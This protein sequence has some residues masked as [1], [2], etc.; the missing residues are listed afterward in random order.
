MSGGGH[1][2][3]R[4][5]SRRNPYLQHGETRIHSAVVGHL[6]DSTGHELDDGYRVAARMEDKRWKTAGCCSC[7]VLE[8][9]GSSQALFERGKALMVGFFYGYHLNR[10]SQLLSCPCPSCF[11]S[12]VVDVPF[13]LFSYREVHTMSLEKE[14]IPPQQLKTKSKPTPRPLSLR[15]LAALVLVTFTFWTTFSNHQSAHQRTLQRIQQC[16]ID[17]L[18]SDLSFLDAVAPIPASEFITRRDNLARALVKDNVDAFVV[19]PGYTSQYYFNLTQRDWEPWEPEER[20]MLMIVQPEEDGDGNTVAKTTILAPSFEVGRVEMLGIPGF[21]EGGIDVVGWEEHW[22]PYAALK[23]SRVFDELI[24]VPKL[25]MDEEIRDYI[26]RGLG[27]NGFKTVGLSGEAEAVRQVKSDMEIKI[28]RAVNTGTVQAVRSMRPCLVP[29][30]TEDEVTH[31]LDNS[32]SSIGFEPFFDIVL[33]E[34]DGALPHGGFVT[35][36]KVLTPE[37]MVVIDVGYV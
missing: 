35:G 11:D 31:V 15:V 28:L 2:A 30:V 34:E 27:R 21:E 33:F 6:T 26:V 36:G 1:Q 8:D 7:C 32:M 4:T 3:D 20:P 13:G 37:T 16:S 19:E 18:H 5:G 14:S 17:N 9:P 10:S 25:M 22:N 23:D 24:D 29:G 12:P